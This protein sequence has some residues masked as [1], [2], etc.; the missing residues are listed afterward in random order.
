MKPSP[1]AQPW[2]SMVIDLTGEVVPCAYFH[3]SSGDQNLGNTNTRTIAEI[4]NGPSYRELR[5]RHVRSDFDGH[6][7][8][9]CVAPRLMNGRFPDFEWGAGFR[10]EEGHCHIAQIPEHFWQ[11]HREHAEE[12]AVLEDGVPLTVPASVHDD[13]RKHGGGRHS[14][15]HGSLY[16]SS[17]DGT[18]PVTNGRNYELRRGADAARIAQVHSN[19]R[20]GSNLALSYQEFCTGQVVLNS[21]PSKIS[22]IE[23]SDCNID[24]PSC[25]QNEVRLVGVRH[26]PS[27]G[28]DVRNSI[29]FLQELIWHGGEP[30]LIP[31]FREFLKNYEIT[32]N[33]NLSFGFMSNGTMITAAEAERL[34]KFDRFN[35]TISVDSFVRETYER[36]R[37][38]AKYDR[39]ME[40]LN[41]L[42][43]M[44]NW[45]QRKV[46][47]A[48]IIGKAN[49]LD[50]AFNVNYAIEN[51]IALMLNPI[52]HYPLTDRLNAFQDFKR[53]TLGWSEVFEETIDLVASASKRRE[54]SLRLLDA[55][56]AVK[57]LQRM[58]KAAEARHERCRRIT[59]RVDDPHGSLRKMHSPGIAFQSRN[60]QAG[61]YAP[62]RDGVSSYDV[63]IPYDDA[64]ESLDIQFYPN[65]YEGAGWTGV[66]RVE[67]RDIQASANRVIDIAIPRYDAPERP[68]NIRYLKSNRSNALHVEDRR[69]I[70]DAY[71]ELAFREQRAG[72]GMRRD[73]ATEPSSSLRS[74]AAPDCDDVQDDAAQRELNARR[75]W[76]SFLVNYFRP[77]EVAGYG[78]DQ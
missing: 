45:P 18:S 38:G 35:V 73:S 53:D 68:R 56:G 65:L 21:K 42:L 47:V 66:G 9:A 29:P 43:K 13:I 50:L 25:S 41:R 76:F 39:V 24:C 16:L 71:Q 60:Q 15:W 44:Q 27:T 62:I 2:Q 32:Q 40:S 14:V 63:L 77:Y 7:C 49:I 11:K 31:E 64:F 6:P 22:F 3:F 12:I 54:R 4:W 46:T 67:S 34:K 55:T 78:R 8:G 74:K 72:F 59:V 17:I 26:R 23:T 70:F 48:M 5:D 10:H 58:Y 30:F 52:I 19:T 20:S 28:T 57:E 33:P 37:A 61:S 1:C 36:M 75:G 51:E 69:L